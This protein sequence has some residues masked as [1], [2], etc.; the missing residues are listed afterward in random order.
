MTRRPLFID[1]N[2]YTDGDPVFKSE[3]I[4]M[5]IANLL[6]LQQ[7]LD[8]SLKRRELSLYHTAS[9]KINSTLNILADQEFITIVKEIKTHSEDEENVVRFNDLCSQIIASLETERGGNHETT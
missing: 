5:M 4:G 8:L 7:A 1:F 9:H 6:E 3:L 2:L